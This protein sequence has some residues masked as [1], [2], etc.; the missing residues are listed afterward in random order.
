[1]SA[2]AAAEPGLAEIELALQRFLESRLPAGAAPH[3][4]ALRRSGTG[5][6]RENWPF[7]AEWTTDGQRTVH[8]LL[9]RRDPP[10]SVVDTGRAAEFHLLE[11]LAGTPV[12][13][14][15]VHWLDD[16]GDHLFRPTM[17]VTRYEGDADRAVLRPADPLRLGP[18][19]QVALAED[20]CDA[21]A[22]LHRVDVTET[23]IAEGLPDPGP[24]PAEDELARWE[25]ELDAQQ[26]EPQPALRLAAN[27][28]RDHLPPPPEH[29]VLV[30]GDFRPANVLV[31]DGRLA[32]L[33]DWELAHLGDPLDD[34]GWYTTPL[35]AREHC[36]PGAWSSDDFLRRYSE[37]TGTVVD[38]AA[39][40]FWQVLSTFRLAV[41]ALT[42]VRAFVEGGSDRPAAPADGVIRQ[43]LAGVLAEED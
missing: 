29:L 43:V 14:P 17:V 35:Y 19:R 23:G 26:L 32:V 36:I 8:E 5:S 38:P 9:M 7:D 15:R 37:R 30:H 18:E 33:L 39:L 24:A 3:V 16:S 41:I 21:L 6:S 13:A 10:V 4:S 40:H 31:R 42:A 2:P 11:R 1:V 28:L 12:P 22:E 20:M 34:L 27:W 25:R